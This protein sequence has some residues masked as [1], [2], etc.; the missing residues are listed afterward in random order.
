MILFFCPSNRTKYGQIQTF[1]IYRNKTNVKNGENLGQ[2]R[3]NLRQFETQAFSLLFN[4]ISY[5]IFAKNLIYY[6]YYRFK[7]KTHLANDGRRKRKQ[8]TEKRNPQM[9]PDFVPTILCRLKNSN[10]FRILTF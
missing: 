10:I 1:S 2:Y 9:H 5:Y 8:T 7:T 4:K 3:T 6:E